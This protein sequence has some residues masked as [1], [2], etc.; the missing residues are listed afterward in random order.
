MRRHCLALG[1]LMTGLQLSACRLNRGDAAP[2]EPRAELRV[3]SAQYTV[4][5]APPMFRVEIPYA[6]TNRS[7]GTVSQTYCQ[8]PSPPRLEKQVSLGAWAPAY[9]SVELMCESIPP[10][11][12]AAG[13]TYRGVLHVVAAAPRRNIA[14]AW[15]V[16]S[17]PGTY[18][19]RWTLHA[20]ADPH[21]RG[22]TVEAT[23]QSFRLGMP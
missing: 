16:D 22:G 2:G 23:S 17:I 3:D 12:I 21:D 10:F 5:F 14:P 4:R 6:F 9:S 20:G 11:R 13:K 19:L 15:L 7:G 8:A 1:A 18:R